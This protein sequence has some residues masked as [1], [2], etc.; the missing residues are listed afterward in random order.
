MFDI[1]HF[2]E[3]NN[4]YGHQKGDE[5]LKSVAVGLKIHTNGVGDYAFRI[6]GEEFTIVTIGLER[7]F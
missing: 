7:I 5:A 6:G 3:Y 4:T 2:K 1:D